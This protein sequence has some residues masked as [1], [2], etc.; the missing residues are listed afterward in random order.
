MSVVN[1]SVHTIRLSGRLPLSIDWRHRSLCRRVA[2]P[3]LRVHMSTASPSGSSRPAEI[4]WP[5]VLLGIGLSIVM[6]AA[7]VYLGLRA[8]MTVSASIP[9]AGDFD[10]NSARSAAAYV[11]LGIKSCANR[12]LSRRVLGGGDHFYDACTL[13]DRRLADIRLLDNNTRR[14]VWW[15]AGSPDD[16]SHAKGF[17]R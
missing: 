16:D 5:A 15:F 10:R 4:T 13:V 9:A 12:C 8:G 3:F 6:G 1:R 2:P 14:A 17:C 11:D 7:N